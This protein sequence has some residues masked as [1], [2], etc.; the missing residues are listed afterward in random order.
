MVLE[1][2]RSLPVVMEVLVVLMEPQ[3]LTTQA[4]QAAP[5][6]AVQ[7]A[8][9]TTVAAVRATVLEVQYA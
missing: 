1:E 9:A 6:E 7:A 3:E 5:M 8:Y 4:L 2:H